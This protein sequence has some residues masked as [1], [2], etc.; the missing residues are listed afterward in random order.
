MTC[1][2]ESRPTP[3]SRE[4]LPSIQ[5]DEKIV[6]NGPKNPQQVDEDRSPHAQF[7]LVHEVR[8]QHFEPIETQRG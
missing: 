3:L 7:K 4:G 1:C 6:I 8:Q 5:L 2:S